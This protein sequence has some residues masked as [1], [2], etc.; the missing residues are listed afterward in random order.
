MAI[1]SRED[2]KQY[3]LRALGEPVIQVNVE[4]WQLEDRI[5]DALEFFRL[6][7]YDGS[8]TVY[9]KH[10]LT[11]PDIDSKT[12]PISDMIYSVKRMIPFPFGS[13]STNLF[14]AEYQMLF[15]DI[16]ALSGGGGPGMAEYVQTMQ[17]INMINFVLNGETPL[18]FN[19]YKGVLQI[20]TDWKHFK[21]GDYI[22]VEAYGAVDETVY[23]KV[24]S[25][26]WLRK[27]TTALFKRQ[28]AYNIKKFTGIALPGGV[29]LDGK[30]LYE[31]ASSEIKEME[32]NLKNN[33][34]PLGFTMG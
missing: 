32:D 29:V 21:V 23:T 25:D 16:Q 2:L 5:D 15:S 17:K 27:Y 1:N 30:S 7:H 9:F 13:S 4:D 22:I 33:S 19:R 8:E 31:E 12:I 26:P 3:A 34:A 24:Y 20:D 6:Y 11:Q 28:W 10:Q 18:R 14:S